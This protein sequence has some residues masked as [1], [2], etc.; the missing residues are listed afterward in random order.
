MVIE[1]H[2]LGFLERDPVFSDILAAVCLIPFETEIVHMYSVHNDRDPFN[3]S[4][5]E[6]QSSI[7]DGKVTGRGRLAVWQGIRAGLR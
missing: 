7:S 6:Q 5:I 1:K 2:R 4:V 3:V